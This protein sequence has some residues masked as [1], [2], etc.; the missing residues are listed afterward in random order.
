LDNDKN[1]TFSFKKVAVTVGEKSENT[2]EIISDNQVNA[3]SKI[4][5]KGVFDLAN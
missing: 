3:S 2:V 5:V 1:N 4:L